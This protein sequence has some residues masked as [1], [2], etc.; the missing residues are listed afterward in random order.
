MMNGARSYKIMT[1]PLN[2]SV[3]RV[4]AKVAASGT[5]LGWAWSSREV[6]ET[7]SIR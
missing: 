7:F 4:A 1:I 3:P 2:S 6:D 5:E